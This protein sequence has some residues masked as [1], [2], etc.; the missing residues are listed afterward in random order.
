MDDFGVTWMWGGID[1]KIYDFP[2]GVD[3]PKIFKSGQITPK[4]PVMAPISIEFNGRS[5]ISS[6]VPPLELYSPVYY[7]DKDILKIGYMFSDFPFYGRWLNE[8]PYDTRDIIADY[9]EKN[10]PFRKFYHQYD[11]VAVD[12]SALK[13]RK[14]KSLDPFPMGYF[15]QYLSQRPG[16]VID[17]DDNLYQFS[18]ERHNGNYSGDEFFLAGKDRDKRNFYL[19]YPRL[20]EMPIKTW[21]VRAV[22]QE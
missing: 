16:I 19:P 21:P 13:G 1:N 11:G 7:F 4:K 8:I 14:I 12:I 3:E 18:P 10:I 22:I 6:A 5:K 2:H 17:E 15:P 9:V 20:V